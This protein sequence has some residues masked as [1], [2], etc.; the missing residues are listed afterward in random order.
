[1][2]WNEMSVGF[3]RNSAHFYDKPIILSQIAS[4]V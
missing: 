1:M 4:V 3:H 2:N